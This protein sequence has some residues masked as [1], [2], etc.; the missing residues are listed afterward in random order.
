[1]QHPDFHPPVGE[2]NRLYQ[3]ERVEAGLNSA[4]DMLNCCSNPASR[5]RV[6]SMPRASIFFSF[7][8]ADSTSGLS[9]VLQVVVEDEFVS[10]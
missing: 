5:F 8:M 7:S 4:E 9:V 6:R 10:R 2:F 1:M 3:F